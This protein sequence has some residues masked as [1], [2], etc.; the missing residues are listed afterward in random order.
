MIKSFP[1]YKIASLLASGELSPS[2]RYVRA[3]VAERLLAALKVMAGCGIVFDD[4]RLEYINV[5]IDREDLVEAKA[6]IQQA[7]EE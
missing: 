7:E 6:S 3:D 4:A 2:G 1:A 5:Q